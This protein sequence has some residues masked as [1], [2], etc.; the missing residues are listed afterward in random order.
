MA[1]EVSRMKTTRRLVLG[2]ALLGALI[3]ATPP[4]AANN[5]WFGGGIGL[6]FGDVDYI[7]VEPVIGYRVTDE[8][9]VGGRLIYAYRSDDRIPGGF[10]GRD[11]GASVFARW[12][13][14]KHAFL[15]GEY[16]YLSYEYPTFSGETLRDNFGSWLLGAGWSQPISRNA[17]FFAMGLY[18]L[19]YRENEPSPYGSAVIIRAGVGF[20][21]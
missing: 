16:E 7:S 14:T 17:S 1:G 10:T 11:Y 20:S 21:F 15:Q 2:F 5:W 4:A 9:T 3:A 13:F 12:F 6:S 8:V 19:S 18:N